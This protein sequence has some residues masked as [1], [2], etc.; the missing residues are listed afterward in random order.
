MAPVLSAVNGKSA[1]FIG[2][3][4]GIVYSLDSATGNIIWAVQ[5]SPG[6]YLGGHN[7]GISV[8]DTQVYA[9]VLNFFHVPWY[10]KNGTTT[11][12]GGWVA[13]DKV[14]GAV[15]WTTANPANFDPNPNGR[16]GTSYGA[17]PA[18]VAGNVVLVG[19]ADSIFVKGVPTFGSGGFAYGK[20]Y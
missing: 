14:T 9:S 18:T 5:T 3:K 20:I 7:W 17:G 19:S 16:A 1:L 2:Q 15:K 8:D 11:Y 13:L 12:G 4:S 6:S 10:L